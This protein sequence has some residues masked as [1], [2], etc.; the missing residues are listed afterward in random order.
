MACLKM[1]DILKSRGLKSQGHCIIRLTNEQQPRLINIGLVF[2]LQDMKCYILVRPYLYL[3]ED[4][5]QLVFFFWSQNHWRLCSRK[6]V[7]MLIYTVGTVGENLFVYSCLSLYLYVQHLR[8]VL[9]WWGSLNTQGYYYKILE[10]RYLHPKLVL[11]LL[12]RTE[13]WTHQARDLKENMV[14]IMST[15]IPM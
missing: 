7:D 5:V 3:N 2:K 10:I 8:D 13:P 1:E 15:L 11:L 6:Q 9:K 12:S 4:K 14:C